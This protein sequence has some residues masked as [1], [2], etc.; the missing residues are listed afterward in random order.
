VKPESAIAMSRH[1]GRGFTA[2]GEGQRH[3]GK[4]PQAEDGY[5]NEDVKAAQSRSGHAQ[6]SNGRLVDPTT[7]VFTQS[8]LPCVTLHYQ[9]YETM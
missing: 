2:D 3:M 5:E 4:R 8:L 6:M 7:A 9:P 1:C